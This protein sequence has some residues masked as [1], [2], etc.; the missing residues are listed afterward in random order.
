MKVMSFDSTDN[1]T[2]TSIKR[3]FIWIDFRGI[4]K[5]VEMGYDLGRSRRGK[6][7]LEHKQDLAVAESC[8]ANDK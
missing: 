5:L 3:R 4:N 7:E 8:I 2:F 6:K 1:R